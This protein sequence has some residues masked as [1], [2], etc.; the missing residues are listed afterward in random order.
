MTDI[1]QKARAWVKMHSTCTIEDADTTGDALCHAR[2]IIQQPDPIEAY[3]AGY[4]EAI[5]D[6][7][8]K[9]GAE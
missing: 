2:A 3:E 9:G 8:K 5:K 6:M 7:R 1:K 4:L